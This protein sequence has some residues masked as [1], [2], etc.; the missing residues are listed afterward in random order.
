MAELCVGRCMALEGMPSARC[1]QGGFLRGP[2]RLTCPI[3]LGFCL[4]VELKE[5]ARDLGQCSLDVAGRGVEIF[6]PE[7]DPVDALSGKCV[8][9]LCFDADCVVGEE[10]RMHVESKRD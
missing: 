10:Q 4:V 1:T 7:I 3:L 9:Q 8:V 2:H 6:A 5:V